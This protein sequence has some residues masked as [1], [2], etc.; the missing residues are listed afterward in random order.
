[1][2]MR[3]E[4]G[5]ELFRDHDVVYIYHNHI[6]AIGDKLQT[7][8][9]LPKAAEDA[10]EDLTKLVRKLTSANFS[11]IL[12]TADHGFLYQHRALGESDFAIAD[13]QGDEILMRNR[14]FVIGRGLHPTPG[15][16]KF[17]SANLGLAGDLDVLIPN[18]IN[19][20]RVKGAG[21]RFVH[22]GASLQ[23]IVIPVI[24]VGKQR[25]ADVNQV[26]VQIIVAGRS[27]I[28]SGQTAVIFYQVQPVSEKM[29]T[30]ELIAG[31]YAA[32]DSLISDEQVLQFDFASENAR[33]REM[34]RKFLLSRDAD[35]FNNQD[36]FL[37]LRMRVGKTSHYEDYTSHR[38]QLKRGITTD[39]DF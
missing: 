12:I 30:R 13:P 39:F 20:L 2:N 23:E 35:K 6:D 4:E 29:Q 27:Q 28:T 8:D 15:M 19:R 7:E 37:K 31:I 14:R 22:G 16:K 10:I 34:P 26:E 17:S 32:D 25:E 24:R 9:Q 36:V 5:K 38:F 11:N 33:E 18:S 21:S 1:M 3:V